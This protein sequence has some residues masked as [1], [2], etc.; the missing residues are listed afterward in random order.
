MIQKSGIHDIGEPQR[1]LWRDLQERVQDILPFADGNKVCDEDLAYRFLIARQWNLDLAE[2]LIR[3]YL[4][5]RH[6]N[7]IDAVL[8]ESFPADLPKFYP[9]GFHGF[10][11]D[12]RPVYYERP[13]PKGITH[14]LQSFEKSVLVRWHYCVIERGRERYRL[15]G[16]DRLTIILDAS[17]IGMSIMTNTTA[18]GFLK[19]IIT[20][21][22]VKFPEHMMYLFV[23]NAPMVFST[24]WNL[25][26]PMVDERTQ[27]KVHIW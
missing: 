11:K 10:D 15:A 20:G 13:D 1:Q 8:S 25:V 9:M 23:I 14:L 16:H 19:E 26:R 27:K 21:D 18:I 3:D 2:K 4:I 5:W 22:Q 6:A 17:Q 12:G 7:H 24:L